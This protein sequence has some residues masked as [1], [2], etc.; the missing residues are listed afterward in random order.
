M[1]KPES[2]NLK[3]TDHLWVVVLF[4]LIALAALA[5]FVLFSEPPA[6]QPHPPFS[7]NYSEEPLEQALAAGSVSGQLARIQA[8]GEVAGEHTLGRFTGSPGFYRTEQLILQAFKDA[9]LEIQTQEFSVVVPVTDVCEILDET[10][11]P[12]PGVTLHPFYPSGLTPLVLPPE[13]LSGDLLLSENT[14][15]LH[16]TGK[17]PS[18]TILAT[19][20]DSASGWPG[21]AAVGTKAIL[22]MEDD[23]ARKLRGNPD[24]PAPW[25]G[26]YSPYEIDFPRFLVRG[27]LKPYEGKRLTLKCRVRWQEKQ[28]RNLIGVLKAGKPCDDALVLS[29]YYDSSS[30]VPD[31]A[32][33]AEQA[34]PLAVMLE[35]LRALTPYRGALTRDVIFLATAGHAQTLAGVSRLM[36]AVEPFT[37]GRG[38]WR[39]PETVLA[40]FSNTLALAERGLALLDESTPGTVLAQDPDFRAWFEKRASIAVGEINL[41]FKDKALE[42]R[43]DYIRAGNPVFR[44]D[45]QPLLATDEERK[46]PKNRHPL[47]DALY[48][49]QQLENKS[50][51]LMGLPYKQLIEKPEFESWHIRNQIAAQFKAI[52]DYTRQQ[53]KETGDTLAVRRLLE[54]YANTLVINLELNSGGSRQ[55]QNLSLLTGVLSVGSDV[56]PQVSLLANALT[57]RIPLGTNGLPAFAVFHW[58]SRDAA[59]SREKQNLHTSWNVLYESEPWVLCGRLAFGLFNSDFKSSKIGTPEDLFSTLQTAVVQTQTPVLGKTF[60]AI[61]NGRVAFKPLPWDRKS[62]IMRL[63]GTVYG[64]AGAQTLTP[65]HPMAENTFVR[66]CP[67]A[68]V[69]PLSQTAG[70]ITEPVLKVDPFGHYEQKL[71]FG[72]VSD[73]GWTTTF[74]ADAARFDKEGRLTFFKNASRNGQ[75]VFKNEGIASSDLVASSGRIPKT[76]QIALFRCSRVQ[77]YDWSN[78]QTMKSFQRMNYISKQGLTEPSNNR[79]DNYTAFLDPD[80]S[81]YVG[82]MAGS[83]ENK[84]VQVYRAF[85]LNADP[86]AP[87]AQDEPEIFGRGY[88][89]ADTPNITFPHMDA[90]ESML[91]SNEKRLRLQRQHGLADSLMIDFH[92]RGREWLATARKKLTEKDPL[93]AVL[94]ADTS[95]AYAI[96]NHPVIRSRISHAII[97][98]LWYLALLVPFVFFFEKLVFGFTD[99][100]KQLLAGGVIFLVVF[101]LLRFFHP[102][103][104]MVR[105]SLMILIGFVILLLTLLVILM[106]GNK[107]GQNIRDLRK[108][109]GTIEGAD[110]NRGGVIGTA[111]MLGLN[112]MRRRKVRTGLTSVTLILI[113][114]VMICFTSVSSDLVN[115][116]YV[117][118]RSPWNGILLQNTDYQPLTSAE[119]STMSQLYGR[120]YPITTR[121]WFVAQ[122][123]AT[124]I[125]NAEILVDREYEVNGQLVRKRTSLAA[126]LRMDWREPEFS[127]IDR[128]L[129]TK[130]DW[131]PKPPQTREERAEAFESGY[132]NKRRVILPDIAA[133]EL[134]IKP[135][136]IN[137]GT[138]VTVSIR[139]DLYEVTGIIDSARLQAHLDIDGR[140][141]L[142]YDLNS[143]QTLGRSTSG[144]MIVPESA[145]RLPGSQVMIVNTSPQRADNDG[146]ILMSCGILFPR[147][148]YVML[149]TQPPLPPLSFKEQRREVMDYLERL[150]QSASYAIDGTAYF[151]SRTRARTFAGLLELLIPILIASLTVF[152]TMR[153]SVYERKDEIYVY[154]AVGIA[155]SHVFFMFMAEA[156]VF[157][158]VG[159]MLGYLLSQATGR[160]LS[161]LDFTGGLNM[162]YSSIETIYA[163]LAIVCAVMLSTLIPA[164]SAAK[165]ASPSGKTEWD[166]PAAEGDVMSFNLPFTFTPH[167]RVAVIS[168]FNRWLDSNGEGGSG[169]FFCSP[170]ESSLDRSA[171]G[172]VPGVTT[173]VWLKPFDL[174]VSQRLEISLPVDPQTGEFIATIRLVRLSGSAAAWNRSV[175]PFLAVLRKQFLTWR[176]ARP[177]ERADMYQE[178][179]SLLKG[180]PI[181]ENRA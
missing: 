41:Q 9:G 181:K 112:N 65:S 63:N 26:L 13:G 161:A 77:Q 162:S 46:D 108:R 139:G 172:L 15:L 163:S 103:F 114:F 138:G 109:E 6:R 24:A 49:A 19:Y 79:F 43:L 18:E 50:A 168:Y 20:V 42:R 121:A 27:D 8:A 17:L 2:D 123:G 120:R 21:L 16:M 137:T 151:G 156:S 39:P 34:V 148:A 60:L 128:Y 59:G 44:S 149:P 99:V 29:A 35:T 176:A 74:N 179:M 45:F 10:G 25:D 52:A 51:G 131:F 153:S 134:E 171:R 178:G 71:V 122:P 84:E 78:P 130:K 136:D 90:A 58:G 70:L 101:G 125:Q 92:N 55:F 169:P 40:D 126:A 157:A 38:D 159:A 100:R 72:L 102:A 154:N 31:V 48:S 87:V 33:G 166:I 3:W 104:Q 11:T 97:G 106:V 158:V 147:E 133:R 57:D 64:A 93:S 88:L 73:F 89:A 85:M 110:I 118:G 127:G 75:S 76:V 86:D 37:H 107:F 32:P 180:C 164:R 12:L 124:R 4:G 28:A 174:G 115:V 1:T 61:A 167:D 53:I 95:L 173:T 141:L 145:L 68:T 54:P 94:A 146:E 62:R 177:E 47:F 155:P 67:A 82:M 5:G 143:V 105:S 83:A 129:I 170:P 144:A 30:L 81:F 22:V 98:I 117:T 111:F 160:I 56:E 152:N 7:V 140:S 142:P 69:N 80:F 91:R 150:G 23:L 96:N 66:F 113:T 14:D 132:V 165:L 36:E 135:E 119:I 116:E 175:T